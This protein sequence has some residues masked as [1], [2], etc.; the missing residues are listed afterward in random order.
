MVSEK[1]SRFRRQALAECRLSRSIARSEAAPI[2]APDNRANSSLDDGEPGASTPNEPCNAAGTGGIEAANGPV[3]RGPFGG[4][5]RS[6]GRR[7]EG[8]GT[9]SMPG[10][11][12]RRSCPS[13]PSGELTSRRQNVGIL[14]DSEVSC[15]N[16]TIGNRPEQGLLVPPAGIEP[17]ISSSH[18]RLSAYLGGYRLFAG[19]MRGRGRQQCARFGA[20]GASGEYKA[21]TKSAPQS[22]PG[23][24]RLALRA[25]ARAVTALTR[26]DQRTVHLR[27]D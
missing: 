17:A 16:R 4:C 15:A 2:H 3:G 27:G 20:L 23:S 5:G 9:L 6:F 11:R 25:P 13:V 1:W 26:R 24:V 12:P 7:M 18:R 8:L 22:G 21:S 19:K 10:P 14:A